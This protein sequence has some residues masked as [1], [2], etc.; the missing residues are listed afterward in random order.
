MGKSDRTRIFAQQEF[1]RSLS[2]N[3][4]RRRS[5]RCISDGALGPRHSPNRLRG[6]DGRDEGPVAS[7]ATSVPAGGLAI[8]NNQAR[9]GGWLRRASPGAPVAQTQLF[10]GFRDI[11][12]SRPASTG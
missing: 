12:G 7:S 4:R 9:T 11:G 5:R 1:S 6:Q 3:D 2:D 8:K 10:C